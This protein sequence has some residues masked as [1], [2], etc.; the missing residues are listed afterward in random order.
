MKPSDPCSRSR[1]GAPLPPQTWVAFARPSQ[2]MQPHGGFLPGVRGK[3]TG[4][5]FALTGERRCPGLPSRCAARVAHAIHQA[6]AL[7]YRAGAA[8][9][10]ARG[11]RAP[12]RPLAAACGHTGTPRSGSGWGGHC[13]AGVGKGCCHP[14]ELGAG[15]ISLPRRDRSGSAAAGPLCSSTAVCRHRPGPQHTLPTSRELRARRVGAPASDHSGF[16]WMLFHC[17]CPRVFL[18]NAGAVASTAVCGRL[19]TRGKQEA[20]R[21]VIPCQALAGGAERSPFAVQGCD[22]YTASAAS[23]GPSLP[24]ARTLSLLLWSAEGHQLPCPSV[25]CGR[26]HLS[27]QTK[28]CTLSSLRLLWLCRHQSAK[29]I[30]KLWC[31]AH[32]PL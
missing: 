25:L 22:S 32:R 31:D 9:F 23:I 27:F 12:G 3:R 30:F 10:S 15:S 8:P 1:S 4:P 17:V 29:G 18:P 16:H 21:G 24:V 26:L 6:A 13:G 5:C 2:G 7:R 19:Q 28:I 14:T 20:G 11:L